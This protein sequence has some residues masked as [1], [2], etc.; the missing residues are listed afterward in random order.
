M[1]GDSAVEE[2][3]EGGGSGPQEAESC[4]LGSSVGGMQEGQAPV[5]EAAVDD[6]VNGHCGQWVEEELGKMRVVAA[7]AQKDFEEEHSPPCH[8]TVVVF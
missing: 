1:V 8:L 5:C 2:D 4:V 3:G 6:D 7:Q